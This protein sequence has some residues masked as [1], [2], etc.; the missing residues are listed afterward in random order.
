MAIHPDQ[1]KLGEL[2]VRTLF[3]CPS[4]VQPGDPVYQ[5]GADAVDKADASDSGKM[6]CAGIVESKPSTTSCYIV[7]AGKVENSSWGLDP[8]KTYFVGVSGVVLASGLPTTPGSIIQ[9][10]GYAK[11]TQ[12]LMVLLDRDFTSL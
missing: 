9:E 12:E 8:G 6:P 4:T 10:I 5:T 1:V 11:N 7:S 3:S 2:R